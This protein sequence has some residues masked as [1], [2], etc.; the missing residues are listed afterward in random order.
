[1]LTH[2]LLAVANHLGD[3]YDHFTQHWPMQS[4]HGSGIQLLTVQARSG[5]VKP[6]AVQCS[7]ASVRYPVFRQ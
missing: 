4:G 6:A 1:M 3:I 7:T 2:D 5:N